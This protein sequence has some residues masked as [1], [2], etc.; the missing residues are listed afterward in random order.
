MGTVYEAEQENPRRSVALKIIRPDLASAEVLRRFEVEAQILGHLQHSGIAQIYEAGSWMEGDRQRPFFA[1]EL[2]RGRP[3]DIFVR[4]EGLDTREVVALLARICEAVHYAHQRGVIHRDLKPENILVDQQ[5]Q[6]KIL[7][8]GVARATDAD[9][10]TAT[11]QTAVGQLLGTIPYM[12]PE[13]IEGD[14]SA[15]DI[16]SDVYAL[17]VIGFELLAGRL[18]HDFTGSSLPEAMRRIREDEPARLG[19]LDAS[20]RGDLETI[21][22]K[23][24][25]KEKERRY[26]SSAEFAAD[27]GRYLLDEPI[28]ARR[29]SSFMRALLRETRHKEVMASWGRIWMWHGATIFILAALT[30]IA[31]SSDPSRVLPSAMIWAVGLPLLLF[32]VWKF[33][34]QPGGKWIGVERQLAQ[35]WSFFLVSVLLTGVINTLLGLPALRLAPV[36]VMQA[37]FAFACTGMILRGSFYPLAGALGVL[38]LF[39]AV[40]PTLGPLLAGAVFGAGLY[41]TGKRYAQGPGLAAR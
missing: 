9:I 31:F 4:E 28:D 35:L 11:I 8:F 1:M 40:Y 25:E 23:A 17:G 7:D 10:Q 6:P 36:V 30:Q 24:I 26:D 41:H 18:P 22:H 14:S 15:L 38:S 5:G 27:L 29:T 32:P 37:G 3:L 12:S 21:I 19:A 16:R 33:R 39:L 20:L 34:I 13:Q 2:V